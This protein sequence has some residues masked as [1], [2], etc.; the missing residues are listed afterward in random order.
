MSIVFKPQLPLTEIGK[1]NYHISLAI[2]RAV[3]RVTNVE[4]RIKWPNDIYVGE[5]KLCGFL[6]EIISESNLIDSIICGIGI[7]LFDSEHLKDVQTAVSLEGAGE[8]PMPRE[9]AEQVDP[10]H[11][12]HTGVRQRGR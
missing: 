1:F 7:N 11:S 8:Y 3:S 9:E 5:K 12:R 10:V 4:A 6:T 2:Q